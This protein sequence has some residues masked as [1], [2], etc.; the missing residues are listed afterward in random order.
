M[1]AEYIIKKEHVVIEDD[2]HAILDLK[3]AG[4]VDWYTSAEYDLVAWNK[5]EKCVFGL[6][7]RTGDTYNL[8]FNVA[9]HGEY[10][11]E[12]D[13]V[14]KVCNERFEAMLGW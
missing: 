5:E 10:D 11:L 2:V 4:E 7:K 1:T 13:K 12:L 9:N 3:K 8:S 6:L 14:L